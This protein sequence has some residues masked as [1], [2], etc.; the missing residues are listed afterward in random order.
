MKKLSIIFVL[1]SAAAVITA[2]SDVKRKPGKTY[3]PDMTDSRALETYTD[4]S[5]LNAEGINYNAK[6]VAGTV[7][8]GD[9]VIYETP[10]D[11]TGLY[12]KEEV[13]PNPLPPL[14]SA[15][16]VEAERLYLINCGICHGPKM[17]GNG[18]LYKGG[19]GP[20]PVKPAT[21]VGDAKY[22]A[23]TPGTMF[24]SVTYGKNMMGP[25]AS[26]LTPKQR[27]M[28]IHYIKDKQAEAKGG[29]AG[30][31]NTKTDATATAKKK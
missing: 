11:T 27:W 5:Y 25:Y 23:M 7:K 3:M 1:F 17:D 31:T 2:C 22:D 4:H 10:A 15:G 29:T 16:R 14:D 30:G 12:A 13:M 18:P 28:V 20:Y 24:H 26:Q 9:E 19:E 6:P 21:L 8:R